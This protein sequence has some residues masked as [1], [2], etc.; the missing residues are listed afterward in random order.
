MYFFIQLTVFNELGRIH[1]NRCRTKRSNGAF[2]FCVSES[3]YVCCAIL[4]AIMFA[5]Y[6]PLRGKRDFRILDMPR[7]RFARSVT[8][9][10]FT[11]IRNDSHFTSARLIRAAPAVADVARVIDDQNGSLSALFFFSFSL[12]LTTFISSPAI[13]Y[14]S[15]SAR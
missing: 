4:N 10:S 15:I 2:D 7:T 1:R 11:A 5:L 12:T 3:V 8:R 6:N 9:Y 14:Q 13:F